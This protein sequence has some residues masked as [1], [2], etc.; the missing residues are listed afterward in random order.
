V[1]GKISNQSSDW[2]RSTLLA[3]FTIEV[4][5]DPPVAHHHIGTATVEQAIAI[6]PQRLFSIARV[7]HD[8]HLNNVY[9]AVGAA[10]A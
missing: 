3:H 4:A 7:V 6:D 1:R 9:P 10:W 5:N 8:H 2:V